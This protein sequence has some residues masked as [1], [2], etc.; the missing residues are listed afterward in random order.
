[1]PIPQWRPLPP[2]LPIPLPRLVSYVS[3]S[4]SLN[5]CSRL[6]SA[7]PLGVSGVVAVVV[8]LLGDPFANVRGT[9]RQSNA[10]PFAIS[11]KVDFTLASQ[12][13]VFQIKH[14]VPAR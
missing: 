2:T 11:Q 10:T 5:S 9:I 3:P 7:L 8:S 1:M 14:D 4:S 6:L 12:R 13:Q